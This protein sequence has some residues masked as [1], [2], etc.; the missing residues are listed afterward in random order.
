MATAWNTLNYSFVCGKRKALPHGVHESCEVLE[1]QKEITNA[2]RNTLMSIM[3]F[4]RSRTRLFS[5]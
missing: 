1:K 2:N 5:E 4:Y 3:L